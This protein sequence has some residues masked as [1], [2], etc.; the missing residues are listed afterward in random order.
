[1]YDGK[2]DLC[3]SF[4]KFSVIFEIHPKQFGEDEHKLAV[5]EFQEYVF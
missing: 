2:Y 1:V 3:N 4:K 5:R